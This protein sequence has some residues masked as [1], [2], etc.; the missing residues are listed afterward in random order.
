MI[1]LLL[2]PPGSDLLPSASFAEDSTGWSYSDDSKSYRESKQ[3]TSKK[4]P[5][6]DSVEFAREDRVSSSTSAASKQSKAKVDSAGQLLDSPTRLT[7]EIQSAMGALSPEGAQSKRVESDTT[8]SS[9]L[10]NQSNGG[11]KP[12]GP[13]DA[14]KQTN[15]NVDDDLMDF[16]LDD[17][18]F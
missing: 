16:L 4:V 7:R 18:N 12:V 17:S 14:I 1:I 13:H 15:K 11:T 3:D 10:I 5:L 8:Q 9:V 2:K 6:N